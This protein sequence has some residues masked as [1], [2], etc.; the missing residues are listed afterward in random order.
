[1]DA[2]RHQG[3]AED[4]IQTRYF[5]IQPEYRYDTPQ[6]EPVL[7]GYRVANTVI[8]QIR[9][10]EAV[11]LIIDSV[12]AA[13]GDAARVQSIQF[14]IEDATLFGRKGPGTGCP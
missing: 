14:T 5:T 12:A 3:I 1:M 9:A 10:L 8:A 13:G 11:G 6:R 7:V 2:L 4:D